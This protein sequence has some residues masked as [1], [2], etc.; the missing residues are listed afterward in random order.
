M[1]RALRPT[2]GPIAAAVLLAG[3]ALGAPMA[4]AA[5]SATVTVQAD[6]PGPVIAKEIYGQF[7]EHLGTQIY[8][9]IW[10][11]PD[12][13]IPN[14]RGYRKDVVE[15]LK[16]LHVPVVRWPGGCFADEY[17]WRD[18]IGPKDRRPVIVN[19]NWGGVEENNAFGTHEFMDFSELIG[20]GTYVNG[21]LGSGSVREMADWV[22]YMTADNHGTLVQERR[23][24]GRDKPWTLNWF[25]VG[26]EVWGCGGNMRADYY[27]DLLRQ[28]RTFLKP[29]A[30][31]PTKFIAVGPSDDDTA[32]TET[33]MARAAKE[34]DALSMHYYDVASFNMVP[35]G[36][37]KVKGS[38]TEF[39][40]AEWFASV[41]GAYQIGT[42]ISHHSAIMDKYDPEKRVALVVDEWGTWH[43]PTP[44]SN[45]GFLQQQNTLRDAVVAA[46]SL[47]IFHA[48]AD[49]V[50]MA[51]IAQ[52]VNVL[53]AMILTDGPRMV[54]T[55]TY[56]VFD[57][58][59][60]FQGAASL[61]LAVTGPDY[62][63][64][65][66][67]VPAVSASAGRG[68]DGVTRLALTNVDP[69]KAAPVQVRLAGLKA[70]KVTGRILTAPAMNSDNTFDHPQTVVPVAFGDAKLSGDTVSVTLPAKS[71]VVL[72][73]Q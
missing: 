48:H 18:G 37:W 63:Q 4:F 21:N 40:E 5:P 11:G 25:A 50:R 19:T 47:N 22:A 64:G 8:G 70:G 67:A 68:T 60:G 32:W 53:Q 27:A 66:R 39:G 44:G 52:M 36:T 26:N 42:F 16:N 43:D 12:S 31:Q 13:P 30:G 54:L 73:L 35:K 7:A 49:R 1:I 29:G 3:T 28:T 10:V 23:A 15:A 2:A 6:H 34:I 46:I 38:A 59:K 62:S 33:I 69:N 65:G 17:H 57:M 61:P 51:N 24:N 20:A 55:P 56:H 45:P 58:Y 72:E 14:I 41:F 9:G 71:V